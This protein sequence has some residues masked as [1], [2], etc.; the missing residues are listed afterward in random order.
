MRFYRRI[1]SKKLSDLMEECAAD[2]EQN[3]LTEELTTARHMAGEAMVMYDQVFVQRKLQGQPNEDE[4]KVLVLSNLRDALNFVRIM[5]DSAIKAESMRRD[6]LPAENK[7]FVG[8]QL[9]KILTKHLIEPICDSED[10]MIDGKAC[11]EAIEKEIAELRVIENTKRNKV[12][13]TLAG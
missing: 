11:F 2:P 10:G 5:N 3:S 6:M 7:Q 4:M 12:V 9:L 13:L 1:V 8:V